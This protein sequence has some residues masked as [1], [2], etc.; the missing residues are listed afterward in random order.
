MIPSDNQ[1]IVTISASVRFKEEI[2][3]L[4]NLLENNDISVL[5]PVLLVPESPQDMTEDMKRQ[6]V[7]EFFPKI[8]QCT[9]LYVLNSGGY[10]GLSVAVE[11]G[12]AYA[13]GKTILGKDPNLDLGLKPLVSQF[14]E[15]EQL[16][17]FLKK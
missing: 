3:Q 16:I 6:L 8:D 10:V 14:L 1:L 9:Y 2:L 12:Y 4:V 17:E 13:L 15:E 7:L 11:M 5:Y